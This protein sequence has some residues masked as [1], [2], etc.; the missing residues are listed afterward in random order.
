MFDVYSTCKMYCVTGFSM[1]KYF[2]DCHHPKFQ[3][4][5]FS[6][7]PKQHHFDI[8]KISRAKIL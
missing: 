5:N 2:A 1:E 8:V 6:C 4:G 7:L 3:W